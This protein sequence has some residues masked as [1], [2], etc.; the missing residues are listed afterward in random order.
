MTLPNLTVYHMT[1]LTDAL[2]RAKFPVKEPQTGTYNFCITDIQ[3]TGYAYN[4]AANE[5][6]PCM[7]V[8]LP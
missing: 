2:G 6:G 7:S 1:Y 4:P 5:D 8:T 3:K